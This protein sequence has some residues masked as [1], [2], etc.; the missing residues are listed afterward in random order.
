MTILVGNKT[1]L[2]DAR[3]VSTAEGRTLAEGQR[4]FFMETSALDSSNVTAAFHIVL[5]EIM[6]IRHGAMS[7]KQLLP[8]QEQQ[9]KHDPFPLISRAKTLVLLDQETAK[10]AKDSRS[11]T[12]CCAS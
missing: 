12:W 5:K 11:S 3:E 7:R 6:L 1:D 2:G 10:D 4:L 9:P 8:H